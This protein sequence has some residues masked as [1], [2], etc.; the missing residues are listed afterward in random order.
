MF[1]ASIQLI[2]QPLLKRQS[3]HVFKLLRKKKTDWGIS[4]WDLCL[5][6]RCNMKSKSLDADFKSLLKRAEKASWSGGSSWF[7]GGNTVSC[8]ICKGLWVSKGGP[9]ARNQMALTAINLSG[10]GEW[11]ENNYF[12]EGMSCLW[13]TIFSTDFYVIFSMW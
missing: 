11:S 10:L 2:I 8:S 7:G 13:A 6:R 3:F 1:S 4:K 9:T 5:V 12:A